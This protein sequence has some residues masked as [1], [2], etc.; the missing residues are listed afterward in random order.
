MKSHFRPG[1]TLFSSYRAKRKKKKEQNKTYK[2]VVQ[3]IHLKT[4]EKKN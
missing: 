1:Q 3:F 2:T 4:G